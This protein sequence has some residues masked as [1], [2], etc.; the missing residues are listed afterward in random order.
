MRTNSFSQNGF[1]LPRIFL[2]LLLIG[3]ASFLAFVSFGANPTAGS[4]SPT[5]TTPL[6]FVGTAKGGF[7]DPSGTAGGED[8]C[9]DGQTCDVF[10]LTL[11]GNPADWAG[12][13]ARV[14]IH[15]TNSGNDYDMYVHKGT[16]TGTLVASSA[17]GGTTSE[18]AEIDPNKAGVGTGVFVVHV[19]YWSVPPVPTPIDQYSG[20][21]SVVSATAPN[22][23]VT[24]TPI[25]G[26]VRMSVFPSP[27]GYGD[28]AGEPSIGSNYRTEKTFSNSS[29]VPMPNG[30]TATYYGGFDAN[31]LKITFNDCTSP[32]T[33]LWENKPLV[34]AATPRG[35]G[36]PIL[37]T[38]N[39]TGRTFVSQEESA[40][41]ST[42]DVTDNDGDTFMPSQGAGAF[43]GFDHQTIASGP[44]RDPVPATA[45]YPATGR[46][47]AVYYAAQNVADARISRSDDGGI[48]FLPSI[49]MY[50]TADC[51]GLHG[52]IKVTPETP[53][54][55]ANGHVGTVYVPNN[56]CGGSAQPGHED[57]QQAVIV[58]EDNGITWSVR[59]IPNTDTTSNRDPSIGI[60]TDGTIYFG[61]QSKDNH[62]RI[63]VSHDKG[64]TWSTPVDVG[65]QVGVVNMAFP[66]V[67]AGDPNRAAFAFYG[68][69]TPGTDWNQAGF[70]GVW[71]LYL[72]V[73]YDGGAT[74]TTINV[75]PD[76]PIQRGGICNGTSE[77]CRNLLDFFDAT[78]DKEGRILI[79]YDDGC[80]GP[81]V[82]GG[83]NSFTAKAAIARQS[84]GKRMFAAYDPP[85]PA[86][87]G[88]PL[89]SA[90]A[91]S[92]GVTLS[93]PFPD[94]GGSPITGYKIYRGTVP[95]GESFIANA[96]TKGTFVDTTAIAGITYYYRVT[97]VNAVG[98]G[99]YCGEVS[100][101]AAPVIDPCKLPGVTVLTDKNG[102]LITATGT[103]SY[104][105]YDL[106]SL[107]LAEPFGA[108]FN[109]KIV[110]TI[111]TEGLQTVPP[112]TRWPVQFR[113]AGDDPA[114]GRFVS[115]QSS[116]TGAVSFKYGTFV[117]N[118]GAYSSTFTTIGDAD[119]EST[120]DPDGTITIVISRS[121]LNNVGIGGQL[122]GFLLRVRI[123]PAGVT[124]D[125]MPD[126]LGAEGQYTVV[127]NDFCRPNTAPLANLVATPES[128]PA[129]LTVT[130][131]ASGST[132]ADQDQISSYIFTFGDDTPDVSQSSPTIQHTYNNPSNY[133]AR[134]R[135]RDSRNKMSENAAVKMIDVGSP[136]ATPTPT[137]TATPSAT[138]TPVATATATATPA[139]T[140]TATPAAT[141]TATPAATATATP[142]ATATATPAATAT[143]TP[144][145]TA[146]ATPVATATATPVATATASPTA[147]PSATATATPA[148]T[149]TA[150]PSATA[151]ATASPSATAT[152]TA[153]PTATPTGTPTA[154]AT[155]ARL[156][157]ISSRLKVQNDEKVLIAGFIVDGLTPKRLI[158]RAIGPSITVNGTPLAGRLADPTLE[159]YDQNGTSIASNDNW[160]TQT[161]PAD[162]VEIENSGLAPTDDLESAIAR[163]INPGQYT[164]IVRSK[165]GV[166]GIGTVEVYDRNPAVDS[167]FANI[168]TRGFVESD[169]NVLIGG[170][171]LGNQT[172]S[173]KILARA[174]GP[175]LK[176]GLANAI[177]DPTLEL[178]NQNGT[179][180]ATN[181]NWKDA[182]NRAAI[183]ATGAQ[184]KNDAE[185]AILITVAPAPYTAIV[186]SKTT[187]GIG[188]IEIYNLP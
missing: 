71:Y 115:M 22:P 95:G 63:A 93:W 27:P 133:L 159:L 11:T 163:V 90:T 49:P 119:A 53:A 59:K 171:I 66:E 72:S 139:A 80:V 134:V 166:P 108:T 102:D 86:L 45:S 33:A 113:I 123:D 180:L 104:P 36:D 87:P 28:D 60:A 67:V 127:G 6:N 186:R 112:S 16:V 136:N 177:D 88:A 185:S 31:M 20:V 114:I 147:T 35:V 17:Q 42:T 132:D 84:G 124:P 183:E 1:S 98:E 181:D 148:A 41:G 109:N 40:A 97:A 65:A 155:P 131:N 168:S 96:G 188:L 10:T 103:T 81:C 89:V 48:T 150:S 56:A 146:T 24:P 3:A 152:A 135:V 157:N 15:W 130:F 173:S 99:P 57:G 44:Y 2:G 55:L 100:P 82:Q 105:G 54:T 170:F 78:I 162:K 61:M 151:T 77:T 43:S 107:S 9:V 138:A 110:F 79:G 74:W 75:T 141:A 85:E 73:T 12:K 70:Q 52:H 178:Y 13:K 92:T 169:P 187:P 39:V 37:F 117:V 21:V 143:A 111:K 18:S 69:T 167:K 165:N 30:G 26:T 4:V 140:A 142:A 129:P 76:D 64:V 121:K 51:G 144:V 128:G 83:G 137:P 32:A 5:T 145:A 8:T 68:S 164:A 122:V 47:R 94:D 154:T 179:S 19:V 25:P 50:T 62:A 176:P 158:L 116:A 106:R 156:L 91:D 34:L 153:S 14:D 7:A 126:S 101:A 46:K 149:P 23:I 38:D 184:P 161:V 29:L 182:P 118:S 160:K 174:T 125:N 175:S 58:S 120:Y 172:G